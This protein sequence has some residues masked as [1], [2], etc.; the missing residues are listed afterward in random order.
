MIEVHD[1]VA[2]AGTV[3]G[4]WRRRSAP[5]PARR[6]RGGCRTSCAGSGGRH[7]RR[8]RPAGRGRPA[9]SCWRRPCTPGR[10]ARA[11]SGRSP[12]SSS[13][14]RRACDGYVTMSAASVSRCCAALA[15]RSATS[16]LPSSSLATGTT[17]IPAITA[18][19]GLVPWADIGMR[20]V[21]RWTSPRARCQAR[22]TSRPAYSPCEPALGWSDTAANPVISAEL[23]LELAEH[24]VV[25]RRLVPGGERV[26]PVELAPAHRHHLGRGVEL[27]GAGAQRDHG[28]REREVAGLEPFDVPQHL[29]LGVVQ[30]EDRMRQVRRAPL[31][32]RRDGAVG[33]AP[34]V[35]QHERQGLVEREHRDEVGQVAEGHGLVQRDAEP[36]RG[37]GRRLI[38]R[39]RAA[40]SRRGS[41]HSGTSTQMVSKYESC[42]T[43]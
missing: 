34:D 17:R 33:M 31:E 29:G 40:S 27:H 10:R 13:R 38:I 37:R 30:V 39:V 35:L 36:G 20:Q 42:T 2:R 15:R 19:A 12:G 16:T 7:R 4:A 1:R 28:A 6:R 23:V 24:E 21:V 5:C 43:R 22:I 14:T 8:C 32:G 9:R 41:A 3:P 26:Q 25:A 11:R 18:L